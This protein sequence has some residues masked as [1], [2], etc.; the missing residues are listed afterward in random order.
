MYRYIPFH[1][2]SNNWNYHQEQN[3]PYNAL[4]VAHRFHYKIDMFFL[5]YHDLYNMDI[6]FSR[7]QRISDSSP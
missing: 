3:I 4:F 1:H 2:I 6:Q 7:Y 5:S